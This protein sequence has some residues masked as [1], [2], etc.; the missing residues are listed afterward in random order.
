VQQPGM[1]EDVKRRIILETGGHYEIIEE[2]HKLRSGFSQ[3]ES[4]RKDFLLK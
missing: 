3:S 4:Y 1:A 2:K